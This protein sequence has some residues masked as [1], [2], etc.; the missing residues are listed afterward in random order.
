MRNVYVET[1][2]NNELKDYDVY[3]HILS[4]PVYDRVFVFLSWGKNVGADINNAF[5]HFNNRGKNILVISRIRLS[6][7]SEI[8]YKYNEDKSV[9]I[10]VKLTKNEW[11]SVEQKVIVSTGN[12]KPIFSVAEVTEQELTAVSI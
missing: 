4:I 5:I 2:Y 12:A 1:T 3:I 6:G 7:K 11:T 9:D 10:Y 8:Y